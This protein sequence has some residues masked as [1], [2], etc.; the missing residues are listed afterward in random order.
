MGNKTCLK[1][2]KSSDPTIVVNIKTPYSRSYALSIDESII[3][4][5]N[6]LFE[7]ILFRFY[8]F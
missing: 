2:K 6:I 8:M 1:I 3:S 4:V 7:S 5:F